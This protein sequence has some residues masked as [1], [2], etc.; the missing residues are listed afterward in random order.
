MAQLLLVGN[1]RWHWGRFEDERLVCWHQ[2]APERIPAQGWSSLLAWAA[3]GAVPNG[4]QLP[5]QRRLGLEQIPLAGLPSWLGIDRALVA[6]RAWQQQGAAVLVADAGTALSLTLV[7]AEGRFA[8]GRLSAGVALQLRSLAG[9]TAALPLLPSTPI[10]DA[11]ALEPLWPQ[12]TDAAMRQ[13]C[14]RAVAAAIVQGWRE[15]PDQGN[16]RC[17]SR[18]WLTGGDAEALAPWLTRQQVPLALAPNLAL[19]GLAAVA[20]LLS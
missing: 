15:R 6:W 9:A 14:L 2:A 4:M 19:E 18:L 12:P 3:V 1:S 11:T 7:N 17:A 10:E 8:G 13:G 20:G 16:G 5:P